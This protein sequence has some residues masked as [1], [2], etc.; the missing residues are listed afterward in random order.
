MSRRPAVLS[1][2]AS[3]V[4]LP[5]AAANADE[6]AEVEKLKKEAA[7][8]TGLIETT[9]K[10]SMPDAP[11]LK[12][13][14]NVS[15]KTGAEVKV[16]QAVSALSPAGPTPDNTREPKEVVKILLEALAANNSPEE[17]A[18]L[19]TTLA[20]SSA[21]NPYASQP[22][23]RF[24]AAM[25]NSA[26]SILLGNYENAKVGKPEVGKG[27]DGVNFQVFPIKLTAKNR[28][29]LIA[30]VD[31]KYLYDAA[32]GSTFC[33]FNWIL[34]Q[35]PKSKNWLLDTVYLVAKPEAA[36]Q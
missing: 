8:I 7:R 2:L 36:G 29:F 21:T 5:A 27:D 34:S 15:V 14:D 30:G 4:L 20:F 12:K 18:G 13:G 28:S 33:L 3:F 26:Y 17:N 19:K 11:S 23:D 24:F 22:P 6:A 31:N 32:D 25:I 9:K 1:A 10:A 16:P 35:D